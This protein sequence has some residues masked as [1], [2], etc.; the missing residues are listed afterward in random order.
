MVVPA[1]ALYA[2]CAMALRRRFSASG[3]WDDCRRYGVTGVQYVGEICQFL[4][5]QPP[6]PTDRDHRVR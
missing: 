3:F 1:S 4:L 2:G 6:Q 5:N